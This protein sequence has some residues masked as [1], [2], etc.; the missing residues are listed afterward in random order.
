MWTGCSA[1]AS[2]GQH[3]Y[4]AE[5]RCP[6]ADFCSMLLESV[7]DIETKLV[8]EK[9]SIPRD[10]ASMNRLALRAVVDGIVK[11]PESQS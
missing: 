6:A 8:I 5:H 4:P 9:R 7:N 10:L 11:A 1:S 3:G 2:E